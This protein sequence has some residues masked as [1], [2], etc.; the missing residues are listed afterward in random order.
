MRAMSDLIFLLSTVGTPNNTTC[1]YYRTKP[2]RCHAATTVWKRAEFAW[3]RT[4]RSL[5]DKSGGLFEHI[6]AHLYT[7]VFYTCPSIRF[8]S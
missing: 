8:M 4:E 6:V 1:R 2:D 3:L 7:A 5:D